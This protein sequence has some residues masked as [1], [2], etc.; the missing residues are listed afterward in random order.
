MQFKDR[1]EA[2][3][4]LADALQEYKGAPDTLVLGLPRGGVVI[5]DEV[6]RAL[7]L[8]LDVFLVRKLGVPDQEELAFGAIAS[9]GI[10]CFNQDIIALGH[11]S[12]AAQQQVIAREQQELERRDMVYRQGRA[13]PDLTDKTVIL[14]DDGIATGAT[15]TAAIRGLRAQYQPHQII[16]AVPV[17]PAENIEKLRQ[18]VD[19]VICLHA[20][21]FFASIGQFYFNFEQVEDEE[22]LQLLAASR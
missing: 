3:G 9:G 11:V 21:T 15:L 1:H 12:E 22:V 18:E 13:F 16:I 8:P 4:K 17:A 5:A 7:Q 2:G 19:E 14:V 20:A 10:T 6:A